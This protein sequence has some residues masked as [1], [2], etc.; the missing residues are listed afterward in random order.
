MASEFPMI[1]AGTQTATSASVSQRHSEAGTRSPAVFMARLPGVN[2]I[3]AL[4]AATAL[5]TLSAPN[6]SAATTGAVTIGQEAAVTLPSSAKHLLFIGNAPDDG[7]VQTVNPPIFKWIYYYNPWNMGYPNSTLQ[8]FRFQLST[9]NFATTYWDIVT[10]NNLYN[11]LAP[12]TN[13]DGSKFQGTNYWR[14]IYMAGDATTILST[15]VVH[16]F[17]LSANPTVWDRSQY[18]DTNYLLNVGHPHMFVTAAN[19]PAMATFLRTNNSMGFSWR[20]LTNAAYQTTTNS[21]WNDDSFTN[22]EPANYAGLIADVCLAYMID[23]YNPYWQSKNPG[24]MVSRLASQF[25]A[26]HE[27]QFD[28]NQISEAPKMLPLAYDWAYS[29]MNASQRSNTVWTME[30]FAK[31]FVYSDWWYVGSPAPADRSYSLS[32]LIITW[33]SHAKCGSSH[34]RVDSGLG[35]F[36]T[37][38]GE[39]DSAVL[40]ECQQYFLNY[41]MAQVDPMRG[42][43]GRGYAEQSWRTLHNNAAQLLLACTDSRMTNNAWF[44]K[45]PKMFA[46]WEPLNYCELQDQF[47]DFGQKPVNG[48]PGTQLYNYKYYDV[49]LMTGNGSILRQQRRNYSIRSG[50]SDF[51]PEYGEAFL[52]FYFPNVPTESDWSDSYYFDE[53]DGWCMSY[54]YPPNN[55]NCFTNGVGFVLSARPAGDRQEHGSWHDGGI[56]LWAYGAQ[57]S[58]GGIGNY[59]KHALLYP[60]LFVDGIGNCTPSGQ[61]PTSEWYS[62]FIMFTNTPDYT[63]VGADLSK[64]YNNLNPDDDA[65][66]GLGNLEAAYNV[67]ANTRPYITS[68]QRH[69]VFPHKK[70]LVLY[71]T[72]ATTTNASF[73]WKWNVMEP[74]VVADTANCAFTYTTTNFFN[75]SNVTVYVK[76]IVNPALMTMQNLSGTNYACINPFSGENLNSLANLVDG[77]RWNNTIWVYNTTK[78]NN[79][80]FMSVIYPVKWGQTAP[81]ITRIDDNT[82]RVQQGTDDDTITVDPSTSPPTFT[83]NLS[84]PSLG[85]TRL[86]PPS[87]LRVAP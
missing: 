7:S 20:N 1:G 70:Y 43:E 31:F 48:Q 66:A 25:I 79:W 45:Y 12:I 27:D 86:S 6:A 73:Q 38:A 40:R 52:P 84:G 83:L 62:R 56:Q 44:S 60:G 54:S 80:H 41:C 19:L 3:L 26:K 81:T 85:P 71:D 46:Y 29:D 24:Q 10:S 42:D 69:V 64:A 4:L 34:A 57:I 68:V 55:W 8:T 13:A 17:T 21:W 37:M 59:Y 58:C 75:R 82:V 16:T 61:N 67:P 74:T 53:S 47:G 77:P 65:G 39:N 15:G 51:F 87:D 18:A 78:T 50:S 11:C 72:F 30:Q 5:I 28:Q 33:D 63:Y 36:M 35:L 14:V 23:S 22:K 32:N 49:S 2:C 76:H 9:N